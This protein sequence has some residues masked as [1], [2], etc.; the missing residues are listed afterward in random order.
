ME[1]TYYQTIKET[2]Y[3]EKMKNGLHVYL[4]PKEGFSKTYGL[5]STR[6]GSIDRS[7]VPLGEKEMVTVPDGVAHFLEHKMFD[8]KDGDAS[9]KFATLGASSNA[10]TSHSRTAYL[11]NTASHVDQCTELLLDFVQ[12]LYITPESIEKEKGIIDQEIGMYD[13]DPDW[14]GYFGAISNLYHCHPVRID[15]AGT[16]ET[17]D[18]I[19]YDILQ[20][21]YKTFY[22][23]SNMMLF[24][25]GQINP[26]HLME[27]I[28]QNQDKKNFSDMPAIIRGEHH[29]PDTIFRTSQLTKMDVAMPKVNVAMKVNNVPDLPQEKLKRELSFYVFLDMLFS[30]SSDLRDSWMKQGL[31][32]DSFCVNF[33]QERDF[34][35]VVFSGDSPQP[36]RLV[37]AIHDLIVEIPNYE[38]DEETFQRMKKNNIGTLISYFNSI[39]TI[40]SLFSQNYLEGL[41]LFDFFEAYQNLTLKDIQNILPLFCEDLTSNF[42][43]MP[44]TYKE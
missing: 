21:C 25:A 4:M 31:I 33:T 2:I 28:R 40:A 34:S 8:M 35:H 26:E 17:V 14:R 27:V 19:N 43:I 22:H 5:F 6:F 24:V 36:E 29:E 10:F 1:R 20:K 41:N 12:E 39:E 44:L 16:V 37:N 3:H 7:F 11:F 38:L 30:K 18:Q 42:V 9:E 23:P 15:I 32:N 13:D